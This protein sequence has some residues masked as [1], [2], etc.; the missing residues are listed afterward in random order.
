VTK[1]SII[2]D[3]YDSLGNTLL[4]SYVLYNKPDQ[5]ELIVAY[6]NGDWGYS[7]ELVANYYA[8][9]SLQFLKFQILNPQLDGDG[10]IVVS[11]EL[12]VV[13]NY[14]YSWGIQNILTKWGEQKPASQIVEIL[15]HDKFSRNTKVPSEDLDN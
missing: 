13:G 10:A 8:F 12:G 1:D 14:S 9:D 6:P 7:V 5:L 4:N 15:K 3:Y 2:Y 11:P